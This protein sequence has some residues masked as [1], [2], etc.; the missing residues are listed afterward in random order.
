MH[1]DYK[2]ILLIA[3][4]FAGAA[5]PSIQLPILESYLKE[6][7]VN[8][9]ARNLYLKAAEIY[10]LDNYNFLIGA[11][12]DS[13]SSQMI[14]SRYVFPEYWGKNKEKFREYF[15]KKMSNN[16]NSEKNLNFDN[17][18][19]LTDTFYNQTL[20]TI[21]WDS[22][23]IIGFTLNYGQFLPS[24]AIAKKIKEIN[25][26][27]KIIFGGSR[28]VNQIGINVLKA[29]DYIDFIVSGDGEE[30]LYLLAS[31]YQKYRSIPNLIYRDDKEVI[32]NKSDSLIDLNNLSLLSFD[33]FYKELSLTSQEIQQYFQLFGRLPVEISRGCWWNKC[34]FCNLNQQHKKYREKNVDKIVEEIQLLSERYKILN[35]QII[36]NALL[37]KDYRA[38]C[39][40]II[41]LEKDL[42]FFVEARAGKMKSEDYTLL[43][44]AGFT[45][46]QTGIE[47]FGKN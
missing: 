30:A 17:Y 45:T 27:K 33:E 38:L 3:M 42:T 46:I 13:Y 44:Q 22:Y 23:D 34:S 4:P 1:S 2:N 25:P 39:N 7:N 32:W 10:G 36:G 21:D 6:R 20:E 16:K 31:D 29:F 8:I 26:E 41:E 9:K 11:P 5:I 43:K 12:N 24:L 40:K 28:T 18:V 15:N 35:F 19:Q 14:F 37:K 47:T